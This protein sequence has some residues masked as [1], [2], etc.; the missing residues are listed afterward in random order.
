MDF[1]S[2]RWKKLAGISLKESRAMGSDDSVD[3]AYTEVSPL[4]PMGQD[5]RQL[6]EDGE[7]RYPETASE[8]ADELN[9]EHGG[10]SK[11]VSDPEHW[12]KIG[13]RTGEDLARYL[14][15]ESYSDTYKDAYG[16]RPSL[17]RL[18]HMSISQIE[19]MASDAYKDYMDAAD[20]H[21]HGF[22]NIEDYY[23]SGKDDMEKY[24]VD[25]EAGDP[26]PEKYSKY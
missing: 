5:P 23:N 13:V 10:I 6:R 11:L 20:N 24:P 12:D 18:E 3:G 8:Y 2:D 4:Q 1:S 19:K 14:A 9:A 7:E 17:S 15:T 26:E 16:V 21:I 25:F 22:H